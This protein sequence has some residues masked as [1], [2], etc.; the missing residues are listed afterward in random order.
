MIVAALVGSTGLALEQAQLVKDINATPNTYAPAPTNLC[1]VNG[2]L[3]FSEEDSLHGTELWM[4]DGTAAGTHMLK[5]INPAGNSSPHSMVAMGNT[6]FFVADD[7]AHGNELWK[8]DGTAAGTVMVKD[9]YPGPGGYVNFLT[10]A[11]GWLYFAAYDPDHGTE[12]WKTDGTE[13]NT[14]LV[15]DVNPGLIGGLNGQPMVFANGELFFVGTD[16]NGSELWKSD[17]TQAGTVMVKDI[18]PGPF[19]S[20]PD[21]LT[22]VGNSVF[23]TAMTAR[24]G[25]ELWRSD[26]TSQ[27]TVMVKDITPGSA[28]TSFGDTMAGFNGAVYFMAGG[29]LW[30]SGGTAATTAEVKDNAG[31]T[32]I[33]VRSFAAT[34]T[35]LFVVGVTSDPSEEIALWSIDGTPGGI[36]V[37]GS[38]PGTGYSNLHV[39]GRTLL[40]TNGGTELWTSDGTVAGTKMVKQIPVPIFPSAVTAHQFFIGTV[41]YSPEVWMTDG[42]SAGTVKVTGLASGTLDSGPFSLT[43]YQGRV[44]FSADD[45]AHGPEPWL[46]D[47]TSVGTAIVKD[48]N[49]YPGQGS[50]PNSFV[51]MGGAL[52][53]RSTSYPVSDGLWKTD[54]TAS[55]T[56][57]LSGMYSNSPMAVV[58]SNQLLFVASVYSA[59]HGSVEN[60][61]GIDGSTAGTGIVKDIYAGE[62]GQGLEG[63]DNFVLMNGSLYFTAA[64]ENA[65]STT[66]YKSDGTSA[67]TVP[68]MGAPSQFSSPMVVGSTLYFFATDTATGAELWKTDGTIAG[69]VLVKDINPGTGNAFE[70]DS[71]PPCTA[72]GS[73]LVFAADD[74]SHGVELWKSDGTAEGTVMIKDI[75]PGADSSSPSGFVVAGDHVFFVANDQVHG[76]ELWVTDGT[77]F[78]THMVAD[79]M[80][81]AVSSGVVP[82]MA[83]GGVLYFRA[84]DELTGMG[85]W[86]SDGSAAGTFRAALPPAGADDWRP[87]SMVGAAGKLF[88]SAWTIPYGMELFTVKAPTFDTLAPTLVTRTSAILNANIIAAGTVNTADFYYGLTSSYGSVAPVTPDPVSGS[89]LQVVSAAVGS[90]QAGTTYH[91]QV[92]VTSDGIPQSTADATFSTAP[93][94][95]SLTLG[96]GALT[97]AF[98]PGITSYWVTFPYTTTSL[99]LTSTV[100]GSN[101]TLSVNGSPLASGVVS[102]PVLLSPGMNVVPVTVTAQDGVTA[103]T[104]NLNVTRTL[105]VDGSLAFDSAT[106]EVGKND[107]HV[108]L[109]VVRSGGVDDSISAKVST[110]NG[111]ALASATKP[112]AA[113]NN[114]YVATSSL[115]TF[116][117]G[118]TAKEINIPI[119]TS[120]GAGPNKAF[121]VN[122]S[123]TGIASG[124]ASLGAITA[125][126]VVI[127]DPSSTT[128]TGDTQ[129]PATPGI[130]TPAANAI[131]PLAMADTVN[132]TG[133]ATDNKGVRR[134]QVSLNGAA[135]ADAALAAPDAATTGYGLV[136]TPASSR[137]TIQVKSS[138]LAGH[139]SAISTRSFTVT[140]LLLAGVA[141]PDFSGTVTPGFVPSSFREPGKP[142]TITATPKPGFV[143]DGWTVNDSTG[144]GITAA[145]Q[146]L[147]VLTFLMQPGLSLTANFIANPFQYFASVH[148]GLVHA[149]PATPAP[150]GTTPGVS[151]EGRFTAT[152][153]SNGAFTGSLSIDG[154]NLPCAG[155][156]DNSGTARFGIGRDRSLALPRTG[157]PDLTLA[158]QFDFQ[159]KIN[160]T[161]ICAGRSGL[162]A[163]SVVST[164]LC[165]YDGR[166]AD[167]TVPL[168]FMGTS[169]TGAYLKSCA[170]AFAIPPGGLSAQPAGYT[171]HDYPQGSGFGIMTITT[172]G[173]ITFSGRL[174]EGTAFTSAAK[175]ALLY[176]SPFGTAGLFV[177]LYGGQG[178]LSSQLQEYNDG[179]GSMTST[180][181]SWSRPYQKGQYY[182]YG[183]PEIIH[184]GFHSSKIVL[185]PDT[186]VFASDFNINPKAAPVP[187]ALTFAGGGLNG[188]LTKHVTLTWTDGVIKVPAGDPSFTFSVMHSNGMFNGT[189]VGADG[190]TRVF[191]GINSL[192]GD[193]TG[194]NGFFLSAVPSVE[195]GLGESGGVRI[196][197]E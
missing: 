167:T 90:L 152:M 171:V 83:D 188:A 1:E 132:I 164:E 22:V 41:G 136:V 87:V 31:H 40:Y 114:D 195:D 26:G 8:S 56:T 99:T 23:F 101:S 145:Q 135:F 120:P 42:T 58:G 6:L 113:P 194:G 161:V 127:I 159:N 20:Y 17:G 176:N 177:Q 97:P 104:Y 139:V 25:T 65:V 33:Y 117:Q 89:R 81:G 5:D 34:S 2:M 24:A 12:L 144:T 147:P 15:K 91:F 143:F 93:G 154:L 115:I 119:V 110:R 68:V 30:T 85:L 165:P 157:K 86:R 16:E 11:N 181:V 43:S 28:S 63:F 138:D 50:D 59:A 128:A 173:A 172:G 133:I 160:G 140:R 105:P 189:F 184:A 121:S 94:L 107:G 158:L 13:A 45:G 174:A 130:A 149:D 162:I 47:G 169:A 9:I 78:G 48:I 182:P 46:S 116:A 72:L 61:F 37:L 126:M 80:P 192:F 191:S 84:S 185:T 170:F 77:E 125:T 75:A 196:V 7:G 49:T 95:D 39:N 82:L 52:Y 151:T 179:E 150:L 103:R 134:V 148:E 187:F 18:V 35:R 178:F 44:F 96:S 79:L 190:R 112:P 197:P 36:L 4:S 109:R 123:T 66:L 131:L 21:S 73:L 29:R 186:S 10:P 180:D 38:V 129:P 175:L 108:T 92:V 51:Q 168:E 166:T 156:F 74:G 118:E 27:G 146:E 62:A 19:S 64:E 57:L 14:V 153:Q 183:W 98:D 53:F 122:L 141:G 32:M 106:Y 142:C 71:A 100:S 54:G 76:R 60:L 55:G 163:S 193:F 124:A 3:F 67:G 111:T 69:T 70:L 88:V 137:N 155:Q 102:P